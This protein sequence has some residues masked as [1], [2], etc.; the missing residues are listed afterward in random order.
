M[1]ELEA[2]KRDLEFWRCDRPAKGRSI[3][4]E[5]INVF[6]PITAAPVST[7]SG[8]R[9]PPR[10]RFSAGSYGEIKKPETI[11]YRTFKPERDGVLRPHLRADEGLRVPVRQVQ[12]DEVQGHRL[13]KVRRGSDGVEASV[14][15]AWAISNWPP[16][17]QQ[18][19]AALRELVQRACCAVRPG[20]WRRGGAGFRRLHKSRC[21]AALF[22]HYVHVPAL[23]ILTT[24]HLDHAH[25][26]RGIPAAGHMTM[27]HPGHGRAGATLQ[28]WR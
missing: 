5:M 3:N 1:R 28:G 26:G 24:G 19:G 21:L 14:A 27:G 16:R 23:R 2:R 18:Y 12:A 13:R 6:S 4:Q 10:K 11:N 7:R 15:S 25:P 9:W 17:W 20:W 22:R 8:S